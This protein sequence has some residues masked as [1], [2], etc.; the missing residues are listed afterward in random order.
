MRFLR[1][2]NKDFDNQILDVNHQNPHKNNINQVVS[3]LECSFFHSQNNHNYLFLNK[4]KFYLHE[5]FKYFPK[6]LIKFEGQFICSSIF[7]V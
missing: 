5:S 4:L 3:A 6:F 1:I 7:G 2:H